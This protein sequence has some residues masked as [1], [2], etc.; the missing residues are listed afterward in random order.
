MADTLLL[1]ARVVDIDLATACL[2]PRYAS[3]DE[4]EPLEMVLKS[5]DDMFRLEFGSRADLYL[6]QQA[7]TG[8]KVVDEYMP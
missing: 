5:R 1:L 4:R 8:Y 2:I 3:P 6:F 7:L